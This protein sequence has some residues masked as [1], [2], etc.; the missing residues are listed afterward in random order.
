[1]DG[2]QHLKT[3]TFDMSAG[4]EAAVTAEVLENNLNRLYDV[5]IIGVHR[6]L[7]VCDDLFCADVAVVVD[8]MEGAP[9]G[10]VGGLLSYPVI[11]VSTSFGYGA[12]FGGIVVLLSM[13]NSCTLG[14]SV[15]NIDN[16]FGAGYQ[17]NFINKIAVNGHI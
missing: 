7:A 14:V 2:Q 10:V 8:G 6:L 11:A 15:V 9:A 13:L 17:S 12:S 5:G 4:E 3:L 16:G 1:L